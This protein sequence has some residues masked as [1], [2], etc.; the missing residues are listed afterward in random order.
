M[1]IRTALEHY[2]MHSTTKSI[3]VLHSDHS[4]AMGAL[5]AYQDVLWLLDD[6]H[7]PIGLNASSGTRCKRRRATIEHALFADASLDELRHFFAIR[8]PGSVATYEYSG[9]GIKSFAQQTIYFT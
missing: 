4:R 2:D 3:L 1:C 5:G 6:T 7:D 9:K 8:L